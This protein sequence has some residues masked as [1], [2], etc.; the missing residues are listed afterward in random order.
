MGQKVIAISVGVLIAIAVLSEVQTEIA[1]V[2]GVGGV[3]EN[4]S[5][6]SLLTIV[7]IVM[8]A[9]ILAYAYFKK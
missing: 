2:T 8:V 5:A 7:P 4:T 1:A 6:G 3:F 9:G